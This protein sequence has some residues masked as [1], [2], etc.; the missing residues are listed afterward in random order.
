MQPLHFNLNIQLFY[1]CFYCF[2]KLIFR[3][4]ESNRAALHNYTSKNSI[5]PKKKADVY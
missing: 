4:S 2:H 1:F 3:S 5:G